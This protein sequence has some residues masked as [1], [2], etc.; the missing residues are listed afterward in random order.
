[1][2]IDTILI[3]WA[4]AKKQKSIYDKECDQCKDAIERY[5]NKKE[6][7]SIN[8]NNFS[9][10]RRSN[11]RRILSKENTPPE[12]WNKYSTQFTYSSYHL[13]HQK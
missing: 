3:K 10:T 11:T 2:D 13:K 1:M 6:K 7:N 8:G 12:I 5:M 9:V 4:N